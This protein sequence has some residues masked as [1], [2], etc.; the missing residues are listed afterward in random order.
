MACEFYIK[1]GNLAKP[2][3]CHQA[4]IIKWEN[5]PFI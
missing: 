5:A 1:A 4:I 3:I 2:E